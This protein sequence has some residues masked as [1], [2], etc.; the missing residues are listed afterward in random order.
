MSPMLESTSGSGEHSSILCSEADKPI[1][2]YYIRVSVNRVVKKREF[3]VH[4]YRMPPEANSSIR[5]EVGIE[6]C[7]HIKFE[8]DKAK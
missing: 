1:R 3:C 7:L 5:M 6:D 8:Y 2:R 4:S